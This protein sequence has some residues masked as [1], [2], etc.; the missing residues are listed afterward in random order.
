[1]Y[2]LEKTCVEGHSYTGWRC[3]TCQKIRRDKYFEMNPHR[4]KATHMLSGAKARAKCHRVPFSIVLE[5]ILRVWPEDNRCPV[6]RTLFEFGKKN[7]IP[8]SPT[9]DRVR[10]TE[11]YCVG[12]IAVISQRANH[13]KNKECDP[14]AFF[15][16][17]QWLY[18]F[19]QYQSV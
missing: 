3:Y 10:P 5:D 18:N 19:Y 4:W 14:E 15:A 8:V 9:L 17:A 13:L 16:L 12:N 6:F 1:M 7:I 2:L 11:G